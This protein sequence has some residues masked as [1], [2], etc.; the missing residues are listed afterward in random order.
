MMY[1]TAIA[2]LF[3]A[4]AGAVPANGPVFVGGQIDYDLECPSRFYP[5]P[6]NAFPRVVKYLCIDH[7][8]CKGYQ[9]T[10]SPTTA[11]VTAICQDCPAGLPRD[12][13]AGCE[14]RPSDS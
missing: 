12:L 4:L 5:G 13:I 6:N 14:L 9:V 11:S 8:N 2:A 1:L 10:P 3:T 7:A